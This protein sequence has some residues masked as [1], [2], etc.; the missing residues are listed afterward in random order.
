MRLKEV[1]WDQAL[2]LIMKRKQ[3]A[4]VRKGGV[5]TIGTIEEF[6]QEQ[7]R[8]EQ[9]KR[10]QESLAPLI[11][12]VVPL[13]YAKVGSVS[14]QI[15][16]FKTQKG[17]INIDN[18]N[19]SL[20][21][22]DTSDAIENMRSLIRVLD[23]VPK[24]VMISAKIVEVVENFARNFGVNWGF[25]G[26]SFSIGP[27]GGLQVSSDT[28]LDFLTGSV[29][30]SATLGSNLRIGTFEFVGDLD[31]RFGISENEGTARVLS[32]PRIIALNGESANINQSSESITFT[33]S[34]GPE[35]G[36]ATNVETT[37]LSLSLS[38]TPTITN[39]NS[40][41]MQVNMS[42]SFAGARE[43]QGD[44]SAAPT[45]SRSA[46]T[47]I[48]LKSGQ[49]AVI[50]GIYETQERES[51]LGFPFLKYIPMVKWLFSQT[52]TDNIKTELLLF[53]TPRVISID[54]NLEESSTQISK[55]L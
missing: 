3:L 36:I 25:S 27:G 13:A 55:V 18:E 34:L 20:V 12:E 15:Q 44:S 10:Q 33:Q 4:Y 9:L 37:P 35:G 2:I 23:R 5:I 1:P 47:N 16:S 28:P 38:V 51:L 53:I 7:N 39:V 54:E 45:N 29:P 32:S 41:Y 8:I 48:L 40:I 46:S 49:T 42:R 26:G 52:N 50:G 31:A 19:N 21:I 43:G 22:Y 30:N 24:Q 6:Q 14:A 17:S 11:V